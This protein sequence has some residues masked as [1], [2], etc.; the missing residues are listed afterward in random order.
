MS[1]ARSAGALVGALLGLA[2]FA[3]ALVGG[4]TYVAY[5]LGL[6]NLPAMTFAA[7]AW[8]A[9]RVPGWIPWVG[10]GQPYLADLSFF[11]LHP[12]QALLLVFTPITALHL[13][14]WLTFAMGWAGT[15]RLAR[16]LSLSR[17][18]AAVAAASFALGGVQVS[19]Q[20]CATVAA[21]AALVP[22]ALVACRRALAPGASP[23]ALALAALPFGLDL[24]GSAAEGAAAT[25]LAAFVM[26]LADKVPLRRAV[27]RLLAIA[28][29]GAALAAATLVPFLGVA[30]DTSRAGGLPWELATRWSLHPVELL[31]LVAPHI[32]ADGPV[33]RLAGHAPDRSWVPGL[34]A[35]AAAVVLALLAAPAAWRVPRWRPLLLLGLGCLLYAFGRFGPL[36]P[37]L[38]EVAPF[39]RAVRYPA[40]LVVPFVLVLALL[41]GVGVDRVRRG[42]APART[43]AWALG[44]L[45]AC[46]AAAALVAAPGQAGRLAHGAVAAFV[47]AAVARRAA[48]GGA[49]TGPLL[50]ALVTF[51]VALAAHAAMPFAPRAVYEQTPALVAPVRQVEREER[52]P[53]RVAALRSAFDA[54][55]D[56]PGLG[57]PEEALL[58]LGWREALLPNAGAPYRLRSAV[59]FSSF[60]SRRVHLLD[61]AFAAQD[62]ETLVR[63]RLLGARL[64]VAAGDSRDAAGMAPVASAGPWVLGRVP[65]APPWCA[66]HTALA[67]VETT[68]D[69]VAEV[70]RPDHDPRAR[71]VVED[72]G[73]ATAVIDGEAAPGRATLVREE[74]ER[75]ELEVEGPAPA[76]LVVREA[77]ATGWSASVDGA[78]APLL[79][80]DVLFRGVPVPAGRHRVVLAYEAPG[81]AAGAWLSAAAWL[82]TALL[83]VRALLARRRA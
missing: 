35:G 82:F 13:G 79:A 52:A 1:P 22:W 25:G 62:T 46:L 36:Y 12:Q 54:R 37:L 57:L 47:G 65:G 51:D 30:R 81:R 63:A 60:T 15:W 83:G 61:Q 49:R 32:G 10:L 8:R 73:G 27:P 7:E 78:P 26:A 4:A 28:A 53:A 17:P 48:A 50:A 16:G 76:L 71:C 69:A 45:A 41:A 18:A 77:I 3:P 39:V 6:F 64:A 59:N 31:G 74:A 23:G 14:L 80:A 43:A 19:N 5:D 58:Q 40:K 33:L 55:I 70:T 34:Y 38:W 11:P 24:L 29:L 68:P 20:G 9:G 56:A 2:L 67:R 75:L 66:L 21:G 44:G 72:P 42:G